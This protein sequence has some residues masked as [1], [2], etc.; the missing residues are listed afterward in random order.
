M[1]APTATDANAILSVIFGPP[2]VCFVHSGETFKGAAIERS[3]GARRRRPAGRE[4]LVRPVYIPLFSTRDPTANI[5]PARAVAWR[6]QRAC[7]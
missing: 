1:S 4:R 5:L 2:E 6:V 3:R 7:Q